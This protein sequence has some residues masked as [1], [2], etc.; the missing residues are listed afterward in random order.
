[1]TLDEYGSRIRLRNENFRHN[2]ENASEYFGKSGE[3]PT[4]ELEFE[5]YKD[6]SK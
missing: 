6:K 5:L 4:G 2:G 1:M 3:K